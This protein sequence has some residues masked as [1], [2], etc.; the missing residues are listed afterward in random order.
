MI[1]RLFRRLFCRHRYTTSRR[2]GGV[3]RYC[4]HVK[5]DHMP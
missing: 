2:Y 5:K 3:C 1:R 4:G